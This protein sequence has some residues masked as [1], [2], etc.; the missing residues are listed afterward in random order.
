MK[1]KYWISLA[2]YSS[3]GHKESDM[4]VKQTL[5]FIFF[6]A[7]TLSL[8]PQFLFYLCV[9][10]FSHIWLFVTPW[11]GACQ[12]PDPGIILARIMVQ[13]AISFSKGSTQPK[14]QTCV[15]CDSCIIGGFFTTK[16][17]GKPSFLSLNCYYIIIQI[18]ICVL[19][20]SFLAN[21]ETGWRYDWFSFPFISTKPTTPNT[22]S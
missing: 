4:T 11:T 16:P 21:Q 12:A 20:K 5:H 9:C 17:Q 6:S 22:G 3:W 7:L 14:D 8:F 15:S 18:S 19:T 2:C 1:V 13:V 10:V